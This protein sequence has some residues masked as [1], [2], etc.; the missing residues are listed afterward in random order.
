MYGCFQHHRATEPFPNWVIRDCRLSFKKFAKGVVTNSEIVYSDLEHFKN[1]KDKTVL[2]IGG[3]PSTNELNLNEVERDFTWSCN[4]FYLNP[5]LSET[6]IDLAMLMGEPNLKSQEFVEYRDKFR[7]YLGF[8][9]HDRWFGYEFDDYEKYFVMHTRFYSKL[10]ACARMILH[11][12]Y[13]GCKTVKFVGL[14][15]YPPIYNGNHAHE[16]GKRLL[17][18]NFTEELYDKQYEHFWSYTTKIHPNVQFM[19]LGGG[20]KFHET[21]ERNRSTD[22]G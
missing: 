20:H 11:A 16:P 6:K 1:Y 12:C 3:G 18:S 5:K 2:I 9:V 10:G 8:E 4:H 13:L 21:I 14:D 19:N 15:G 7:P 22:S 17:P